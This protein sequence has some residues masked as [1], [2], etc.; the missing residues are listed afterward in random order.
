MIVA[1]LVWGWCLAMIYET[2]V[3]DL[4]RGDAAF[5]A[6]RQPHRD[7]E[8]EEWSPTSSH[9]TPVRQKAQRQ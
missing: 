9:L 5:H 6:S 8:E 2:L 7:T 4:W 1:H 3:S